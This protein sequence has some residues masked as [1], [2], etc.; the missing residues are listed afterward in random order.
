MAGSSSGSLP[1]QMK[2]LLITRSGLLPWILTYV[3]SLVA[4]LCIETLL[5]YM[6]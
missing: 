2:I 5:L 3:Q 4:T 1:F 6:L